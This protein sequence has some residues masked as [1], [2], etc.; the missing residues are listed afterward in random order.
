MKKLTSNI[1]R[2]KGKVRGLCVQNVDVF[3]TIGNH[4]GTRG[5]ARS[6]DLV[7]SDISYHFYKEIIFCC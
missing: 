2:P 4:T 3:T 1:S 7:Y 5:N 6:V